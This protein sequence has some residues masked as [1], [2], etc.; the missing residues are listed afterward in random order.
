[1]ILD[2]KVALVTGGSRGIGRETALTLA[3]HGADVAVVA[4]NKELAD[5]TAADVAA[6][7]RKS[8]AFQAD[9]ADLEAA[10]RVVDAMIEGFERIDV[11]VNNAGITR[12]NLMLRMSPEE[13]DEV[14]RVN[15]RG[16]FN[17]ATLVGQHMLRQRSGAIINLSSVVALVGN[18]GQANYCAS[19]AGVIG[20]TKAVAR[21]LGARSIRV[22][23]VAPGFIETDMTDAV[24]EPMKEKLLSGVPLK[25]PG[26]PSEVAE[27]VA[28]LASDAAS[29][30][31]G[32][33]IVVDGGMT[34]C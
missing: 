1:M 16:V 23:A 31:T 11:L 8:R 33:V 5:R 24:A 2:G 30:I 20:F 32:Q 22:N 9:V 21:E 7:G 19:K 27:V 25:R 17:Y 28:F 4:R 13:W 3:R 10:E 29:Y 18:A 26:K 34:M 14:V 6:L 12:D 15:L